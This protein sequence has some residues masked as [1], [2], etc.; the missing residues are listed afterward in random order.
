MGDHLLMALLITALMIGL[1]ATIYFF[2]ILFGVFR[3]PSRLR[4]GLESTGIVVKDH[5]KQ[6]EGRR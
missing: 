1:G 4:R 3:M 5:S 2:G 6:Q